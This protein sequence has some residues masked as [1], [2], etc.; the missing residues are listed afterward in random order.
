MKHAI[1]LFLLTV[2]I[3]HNVVAMDNQKN[4]IDIRKAWL[5][6]DHNKQDENGNTF[7]HNLVHKSERFEDW[8][9]V[10]QEENVFK[11]NNK[12]W[13]PNPLI[14]NND[15]RTARQEAKIVFKRSGNPVA[16]LLVINLRQ[17]E[18]SFLSTV[19]L[20][21]NRKLMDVAQYFDY[22]LTKVLTLDQLTAMAK[23]VQKVSPWAF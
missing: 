23:D 1:K 14:C 16:G 17:S 2:V 15:G 3:T 20:K 19:A 7:W 21:D 8:S 18:D 12:N 9:E 13:M 10:K 5:E 4:I 6:F 11:Q 22:D